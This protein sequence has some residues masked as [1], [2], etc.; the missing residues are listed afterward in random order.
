[1]NMNCA[2]VESKRNEGLKA[3]N[4]HPLSLVFFLFP[5]KWLSCHSEQINEHHDLS[6]SNCSEFRINQIKTSDYG[7]PDK[8]ISCHA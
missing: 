2:E 5:Q 4:S 1:M 6:G 8:K 7:S 3:P